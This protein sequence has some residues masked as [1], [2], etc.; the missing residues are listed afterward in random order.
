[1]NA[2]P[3][4]R[5]DG[6]SCAIRERF[7]ARCAARCA[8]SLDARIRATAMSCSHVARPRTLSHRRA[9]Q[10]PVPPMDFFIRLLALQPVDHG[11]RPVFL[12]EPGARQPGA[13]AAWAGGADRAAT[14]FGAAWPQF[15]DLPAQKNDTAETRML[16]ERCVSAAHRCLPPPRALH[17]DNAAPF[18][19]QDGQL[20]PA[21]HR[22]FRSTAVLTPRCGWPTISPVNS[23]R[24]NR[25]MIWGATSDAFVRSALTVAFP[26]LAGLAEFVSSTAPAPPI[27]EMMAPAGWWRL[28]PLWVTAYHVAHAVNVKR[29]FYLIQ[30]F[31]PMFYPAGT[32]YALTERVPTSSACLGLQPLKTCCASTKRTTAATAWRSRPLSTRRSS[33]QRTV[34]SGHPMRRLPSL[35]TRGPGHWRIVEMASLALGGGQA[36]AGPPGTHCHR[37]SWATERGATPTSGLGWLDYRATGRSSTD[38][39]TSGL[40]RRSRSI[41][42][43][44]PLE[45]MS[46]GVPVVAFDNP[47][48]T[49]SCGMA[50]LPACQADGRQLADRSN[51]CA[52]T[53]SWRHQLQSRPLVDI[54]DR[55]NDWNAA[56]SGIYGYLCDPEGRHLS[57]RIVVVTEEPLA[58][59]MPGRHPRDRACASA[60]DVVRG[61]AATLTAC[62]RDANRGSGPA[63]RSTSPR[64]RALVGSARRGPDPGATCGPAAVAGDTLRSLST[65]TTRSI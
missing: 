36:S 23:E 39:A 63:C 59:R 42:P 28:R 12:A 43:T 49:G 38:T 13:C 2:R 56:F 5:L 7:I 40:A 62:T 65:R 33:M 21:G 57:A 26:S 54:A 20:V 17:R 60:R 19:V 48:G 47:W 15:R 45:L 10:A 11:R 6:E 24:R 41:R 8:F 35:S 29:K 1:M 55:H 61:D 52:S 53:P 51:G 34:H 9:R 3:K 25:F 37:G 16:T 31:E 27:F 44:C 22:Q 14:H 32:L 64:W 4:P 50:R 30:D 58:A 18:D 46:C